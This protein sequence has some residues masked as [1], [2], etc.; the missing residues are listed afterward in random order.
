MKTTCVKNQTSRHSMKHLL[1]LLLIS[2]AL[3]ALVGCG[4]GAAKKQQNRTFFTSGSREADQRASQRMAKE[5]QLTGSGEG[6]G[7]KNV[8]KAK[9]TGKPEEAEGGTN[10]AAK[11]EQK[12]ALFDRLGGE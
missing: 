11:A 1:L 10:K 4:A 3:A 2:G 12:L 6:A 7:E 8:K 9:P 5:E